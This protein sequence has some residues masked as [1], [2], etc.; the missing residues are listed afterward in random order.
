M[1]ATLAGL[2]TEAERIQTATVRCWR[3]RAR[4]RDASSEHHVTHN[5]SLLLLRVVESR[6]RHALAVDIADL[7]VSYLSTP[8]TGSVERHEQ[9][10]M[11]G[12]A[13]GIDESCDLFLAEDRW[14][15]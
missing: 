13:S 3:R 6:R 9:S 15:V 11:E 7:Q 1:R 5:E 8:Q 4:G 10:A 14:K 2:L 12:S